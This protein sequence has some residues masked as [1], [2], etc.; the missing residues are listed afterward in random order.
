MLQCAY[1]SLQLFV[2]RRRRY[3]TRLIAATSHDAAAAA[4]AA[5]DA[6]AASCNAAIIVQRYSLINQ[7]GGW[8]MSR[9]RTRGVFPL[10]LCRHLISIHVRHDKAYDP[11]KVLHRRTMTF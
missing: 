4:A 9:R 1:I 6:A 5:V 11:G 8:T 2:V 10:K 7:F 3:Y